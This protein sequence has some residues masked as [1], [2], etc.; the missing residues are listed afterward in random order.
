MPD[1]AQCR[2][3]HREGTAMEPKWNVQGKS[4]VWFTRSEPAMDHFSTWGAL[5]QSDGKPTPQVGCFPKAFSL[6]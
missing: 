6:F 2:T 5:R 4:S 3:W 1:D